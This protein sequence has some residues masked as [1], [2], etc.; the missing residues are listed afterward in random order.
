MAGEEDGNVHRWDI[1]SL[2]RGKSGQSTSQAYA[3]ILLNQSIPSSYRA[4]VQHIW[5]KGSFSIYRDHLV[6]FKEL[7]AAA[8]RL[9]AD[10]GANVLYDCFG[11]HAVPPHEIR[12]DLDSLRPDVQEYFHRQVSV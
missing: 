1:G 9:C 10:G 7:P 11:K 2:L 6:V 8:F 12:G 3:A 4:V 5:E